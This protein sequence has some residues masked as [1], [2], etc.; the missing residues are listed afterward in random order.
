M[1][2][3]R[4]LIIHSELVKILVHDQLAGAFPGLL[5]CSWACPCRNAFLTA[6]I[7]RLIPSRK[8]LA[9]SN[10]CGL[11]RRAQELGVFTVAQYANHGGWINPRTEICLTNDPDFFSVAAQAKALWDLLDK[12]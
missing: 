11:T 6:N 1:K 9:E 10:F 5:F 3:R 7:R 12:R 8:F 4:E 2:T